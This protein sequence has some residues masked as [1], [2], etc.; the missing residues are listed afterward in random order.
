MGAVEVREYGMPNSGGA[1]DITEWGNLGFASAETKGLPFWVQRREATEQRFL[2]L[3]YPPHWRWYFLERRVSLRRRNRVSAVLLE[4][5]AGRHWS[6][7]ENV[8]VPAAFLLSYL[9]VLDLGLSLT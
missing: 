3:N 9:N 4:R 2:L 8:S 6:W 7:Y 5:Y 1:R